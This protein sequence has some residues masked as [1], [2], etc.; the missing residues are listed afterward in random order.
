V[1]TYEAYLANAAR[2]YVKAGAH[3]ILSSQT[4]NNP[5]ESGTFVYSPSRFTGYAR[6]AATA[7]GAVFVDHGLYVADVF[8]NDGKPV[9]RR[10]RRHTADVVG[11]RRDDGRWVLPA[12]SH[13]H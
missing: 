6:D 13:A 10:R 5:W 11:C 1:L 4:P 2:T 8:K 7:T 3:V 12:R 9:A